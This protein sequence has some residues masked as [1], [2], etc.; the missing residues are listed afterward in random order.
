LQARKP[1]FDGDVATIG[2]TDFAVKAL[3]D[4]IGMACAFVI[5]EGVPPRARRKT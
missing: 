2:I 1:H 3:T 4:E 5:V